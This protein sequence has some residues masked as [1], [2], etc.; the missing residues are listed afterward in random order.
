MAGAVV[1]AAG[2]TAPLT[3]PDL[4]YEE[5]MSNIREHSIVIDTKRASVMADKNLVQVNPKS[6]MGTY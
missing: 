2:G 3:L 6:R 4:T 1:A 5:H